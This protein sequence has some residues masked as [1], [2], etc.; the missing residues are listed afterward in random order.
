VQELSFEVSLFERKSLEI[1][2]AGME[3]VR[4]YQLHDKTIG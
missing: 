4:S 2:V 3:I 1:V